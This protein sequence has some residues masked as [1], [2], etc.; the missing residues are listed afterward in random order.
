MIFYLKYCILI[1]FNLYRLEVPQPL[2]KS[3]HTPIVFPD[4]LEDQTSIYKRKE[5]PNPEVVLIQRREDI[6]GQ[7]KT[8]EDT[9]LALVE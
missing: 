1:L 9:L 4:T 5:M 7:R 6:T 8:L 2:V 3:I